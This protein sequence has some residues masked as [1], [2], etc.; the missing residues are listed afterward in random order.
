MNFSSNTIQINNIL[1]KNYSQN[2]N[3]K[4]DNN[5]LFRVQRKFFCCLSY[6]KFQE[7]PD[8]LNGPV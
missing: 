2:S 5:Q 3:K 7:L 8:N 1:L 6:L 4:A